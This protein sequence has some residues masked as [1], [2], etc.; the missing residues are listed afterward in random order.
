MSFDLKL[1]ASYDSSGTVT[2]K[3]DWGDGATEDRILSP[4]KPNRFTHQY[5]GAGQYPVKLVVEND[6]SELSTEYLVS[7]RIL[8]MITVHKGP[9]INKN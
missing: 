7:V 9:A 4:D 5:Q 1:E 6:V 2:L 3:N 8:Y